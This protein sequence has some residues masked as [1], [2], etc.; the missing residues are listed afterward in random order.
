MRNAYFVVLTLLVFIASCYLTLVRYPLPKRLAFVLVLFST[1][2]FMVLW[3]LSEYAPFRSTPHDKR[4]AEQ[5]EQY[6]YRVEEQARIGKELKRDLLAIIDAEPSLE[7]FREQVESGFVQSREDLFYRSH[8]KELRTCPHLQPLEALLRRHGC[9]MWLNHEWNY[10]PIPGNITAIAVLDKQQ[11]TPPVTYKEEEYF[12]ERSGPYYQANVSC[13][14]C[15]STI[16]CTHPKDRGPGTLIL[17][18][19]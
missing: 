11:F 16:H 17:P 5:M 19:A 9:N 13:S 7:R 10:T 12:D 4:W 8:Q 15:N 3:F 6:R 1:L 2:G 14:Q 18:G